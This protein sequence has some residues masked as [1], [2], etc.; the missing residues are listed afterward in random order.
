MKCVVSHYSK[1]S[2]DDFP[3]LLKVIL[4]DSKS[5]NEI[6]LKRTKI[7]YVINYGLKEYF[8]EV[9]LNKVKKHA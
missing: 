1:R 5:V 9:C 2:M 8:R 4:P 7:N 6:N 3:D